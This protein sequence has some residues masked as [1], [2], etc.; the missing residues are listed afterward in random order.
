M[1]ALNR[2]QLQG[3][4]DSGMS[5][6]PIPCPV[7]GR[8]GYREGRTCPKQNGAGVCISCC[9]ACDCYRPAHPHPCAFYVKYPQINYDEEITKLTNKINTLR[10]KV[11]YC[12]K[13]NWT[14]SAYKLEKEIEG[15]LID[16]RR[17]EAEKNERNN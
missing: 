1:D 8:T 14:K 5:W 17:M 11:R 12:Y 9:K 2:P 13:K 3:G 4:C 10:E 15:L 16:R 7:C 6:T